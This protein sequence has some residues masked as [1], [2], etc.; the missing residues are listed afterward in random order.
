MILIVSNTGAALIHSKVQSK[1]F[2]EYEKIPKTILGSISFLV[3]TVCILFIGLLATGEEISIWL[4]RD[5]CVI[6]IGVTITELTSRYKTEL[7][8]IPLTSYL[9]LVT[10]SFWEV[11]IWLK[12]GLLA[13]LTVYCMM[14]QKITIPVILQV[15]HI[16]FFSCL[17][18]FMEIGIIGVLICTGVAFNTKKEVMTVD[19]IWWIHVYVV[20]RC[21]VRQ[22]WSI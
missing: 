14:D 2:S 22:I 18:G 19:E 4:L 7:L 9:L 8:L 10:K 1:K 5:A 3:I 13:I 21:I 17:C 12:I 6:S 20:I 16:W 15:F 11:T